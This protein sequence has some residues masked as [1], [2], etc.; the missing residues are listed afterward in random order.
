[1][2]TIGDVAKAAGVSRSTVSYALSGKRTIS[3]ETRERIESAIR[4]LG[5]TPNAG[6]RALATSQ[7]RVIGLLV[8]FFRDE[9]S[10]AMMQY[11]LPISDAAREAGYDILMVTEDDGPHALKRITDSDMVDGLVLLNVAHDDPR[12]GPLRSAR[13]PGALVGLPRDTDGLDVFDLDFGEAARMLVDHLQGLGHREIIL[14]SPNEHVITRGGAYVWRFRDAA[15]E[16]AARYGLRI[17]PYYGETQQPDVA[18]Q[19][20]QVLDA[21]PTATA[22]IVH[23]DAMIAGLPPV[24]NARGVEV[25]RDLSVVGI[26]SEDFGRLF[27]LPYTAIETS[28]D[29]LG[30]A[31]VQALVHRM[32]DG[33]GAGA[34]VVRF[35][36][37]ELTDRGSTSTR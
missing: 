22:V 9:F 13:Q 17:Y 36:A 25:P 37:P 23:N 7:T 2:A 14:V 18:E 29:K 19:W 1:M 8:Q 11:V 21:R 24:L 3:D 12:V 6:A 4:E 20:N 28:P 5:F 34:P 27:S 33:E 15:L 35:I 10:P 16:R 30:R 26:F 32:R 31:A